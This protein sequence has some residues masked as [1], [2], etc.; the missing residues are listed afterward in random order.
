LLPTAIPG[1]AE[2]GLRLNPSLARIPDEMPAQ[3]PGAEI[4]SSHWG[5]FFDEVLRHPD[6]YGITNTTDACAGRA[7]HDEDT[8]P[9]AHPEAHYYYHREHPSTATHKAVG[10]MLYKELTGQAQART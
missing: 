9:C 8:T 1:F 2:A 5:P 4:R 10:E 6:R 7:I 3:L